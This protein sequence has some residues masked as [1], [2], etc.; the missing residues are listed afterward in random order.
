[1]NLNRLKGLL[2][3]ALLVVTAWQTG[4]SSVLF[5]NSLYI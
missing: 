5:G 1:L 3:A 2:H 4:P